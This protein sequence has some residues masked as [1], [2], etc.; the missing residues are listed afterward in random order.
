M[1]DLVELCRAIR[2]S[3]DKPPDGPVPA[4]RGREAA[5]YAARMRRT[6]LRVSRTLTPDLWSAVEQVCDVLGLARLPDVFVVSDPNPMAMAPALGT[7]SRPIVV[8]SSGLVQ[9]LQPIE[10]QFVLGH[11]L[12]HLGL[13]HPADRDLPDGESTYDVLAD[14]GRQRCGEISADRVGL[15]AVRSLYT[16]AGVMI[17]LTSGLSTEHIRLDAAGFLR[18]LTQPDPTEPLECYD[19]HPSLP[20]RLQALV[21]FDAS[22]VRSRL[23]GSG[24]RGE[25][26]DEID[27]RVGEL[28]QR[29]GEGPLAGPEVQ[30]VELAAAWLGAALVLDDGRLGTQEWRVLKSLIGDRLAAKAL[31]FGR[32]LGLASVH[33]KLTDAI[34]DL[35]DGDEGLNNRLAAVFSAFTD[36][37][38]LDPAA[39][40]VWDVL[41]RRLQEAIRNGPQ[42]R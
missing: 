25:P 42:P 32:D 18:Q 15:L 41:P 10:I 35:G 6:G 24:G 9:L 31:H 16:A 4:G 40:R 22:D 36:Q 1:A 38:G 26:L 27:R 11:E 28:L 19:T 21:W 34:A 14:R 17:K 37:L 13:G 12:G 33:R 39:T 23:T 20:L 5:V 29:L 7:D 8:L 2:F 3:L 30:R